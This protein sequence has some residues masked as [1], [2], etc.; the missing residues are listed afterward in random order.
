MKKFIIPFFNNVISAI[1]GFAFIGI[2]SILIIDFFSLL[3]LQYIGSAF[4]IGGA[5][6]GASGAVLLTKNSN[7]E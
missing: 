6:I 2:G 7:K 4:V 5:I 1:I 3:S